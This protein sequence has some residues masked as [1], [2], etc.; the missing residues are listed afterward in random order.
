MVTAQFMKTGRKKTPQ[1]NH[2]ETHVEV[3]QTSLWSRLTNS[4]LSAFLYGSL[5]L[6]CDQSNRWN[7]TGNN[8][9]ISIYSRSRVNRLKQLFG[10]QPSVCTNVT[11]CFGGGGMQNPPRLRLVELTQASWELCAT[12]RRTRLCLVPG[13]RSGRVWTASVT[14]LLLATGDA[15]C[16]RHS[17]KSAAEGGQTCLTLQGKWEPVPLTTVHR[18]KRFW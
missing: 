16:L 3:T 13:E 14:G 7:V 18:K 5:F 9:N 17:L 10:L 11:G 12:K 2:K 1:N 4:R 8:R 15:W 6:P